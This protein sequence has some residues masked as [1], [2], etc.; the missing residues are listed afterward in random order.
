M[1]IAWPL[2][3]VMVKPFSTGHLQRHLNWL[4]FS[5]RL[6]HLSDQ[7]L[8]IGA[9]AC[10]SMPIWKRLFMMRFEWSSPMTTLD[11]WLDHLS[12]R[13]LR[14]NLKV[15]FDDENRVVKPNLI[16]SNQA[17]D[18]WSTTMLRWSNFSALVMFNAPVNLCDLQ[19]E[20]P[21]LDVMFISRLQDDLNGLPKFILSQPFEIFLCLFD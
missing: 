15:I 6:D 11:S 12:D 16:Q 19:L 4:T 7:S 9:R 8:S 2:V 10:Q 21:K 1:V 17:L 20:K 18:R 14:M 5:L 13:S 3:N